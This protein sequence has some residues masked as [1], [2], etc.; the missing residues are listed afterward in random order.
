MR[1]ELE[2][3]E[4]IEK[5][6]RGELSEEDKKAFEEKLKTDV[7]LQKEV[8]IQRDIITGIERLGTKQAIQKAQRR[9][10]N[11]RSGFFFGLI[12][13][14][15]VTVFIAVNYLNNE[16]KQKLNEISLT[17]EQ[18][19][20]E[21]NEINNNIDTNSI[22]EKL[23]DEQTEIVNLP[24]KEFQFFTIN[25]SRDTTI[26][27][28]EGTQFTFKA[29]S[30]K[31]PNSSLIQI[32]LKEYYKMSDIVF[33]NLSTETK[34]NELLETGGMI[35]V[36]AKLNNEK[37]ELKNGMTFGIKYPTKNKKEGMI[38]FDGEEKNKKVVWTESK[39]IQTIRH[40]TSISEDVDNSEVFVI[41]EDM[42]KFKGG[43]EML[44]KH[45]SKN[46]QYPDE[47]KN[48]QI[49]GT[50]YVNFIVNTNGDIGNIRIIK[51][52]HPLLDDEAL[53]VVKNMPRWNPGKQ[54]GKPIAV[55]YNLPITFSLAGVAPWSGKIPEST[56][57][58]NDSLKTEKKLKIEKELF[59]EKNKAINVKKR[60]E[61]TTKIDISN[62]VLSSSKLGW[63][64]CDRFFK[65]NTP[66]TNLIVKTEDSNT[67]IK[68][69]FHSYR[70]VM[71]AYSQYKICKFLNIP[72][73]EKITIVAIKFID[74]IPMICVQEL[75][76][77]NK[78]VDLNFVE[79]TKENLK[80]YTNEIDK[81]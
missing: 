64:N 47:A 41:V 67:D 44:F 66:K 73:G 23:I 68:I 79:L 6:L 71:I 45:L 4:I 70:S 31:V 51:G 19:L 59:D 42:P 63:L 56:K 60:D 20:I 57:R 2:Q 29:S 78:I 81:I 72:I 35:Y 50:V 46:V 12:F 52:V 8:A 33:S 77:S 22:E 76:V 21:Q 34:G 9:Y 7:K 17:E 58:Y 25:S 61:E 5:Y 48:N 80:L 55:S 53:R 15:V 36:D 18:T 16:P 32:R 43:D 28:K 65:I 11:R 74:K 30:F 39:E 37:I 26:V 10:D 49:S 69:I 14:I 38:L 13:T 40:D 54:Q 27:G 3:I 24:S 75:I 1:N 62:Y